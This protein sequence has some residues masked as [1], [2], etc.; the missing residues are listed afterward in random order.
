M[1]PATGRAQWTPGYGYWALPSGGY[2]RLSVSVR[3][4]DR[5]TSTAHGDFYAMQ[6]S[7]EFGDG[8]YVGLQRRGHDHDGTVVPEMAIFSEI[9]QV[10]PDREPRVV[11]FN[12]TEGHLTVD[13]VNVQIAAAEEIQ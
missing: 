12:M 10:D 4:T 9:N 5:P 7:T 3:V 2:T 6:F 8:G 11:V 13:D 1:F